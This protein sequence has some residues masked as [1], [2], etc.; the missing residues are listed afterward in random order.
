MPTLSGAFVQVLIGNAAGTLVDIS[1]YLTSVEPQRASVPIDL[2]TFAAGGVPV[3][4]NLVRGAAQSEFT[5]KGLYDPAFA[6]IIRQIM[7]ARG[8]FTLQIRSGSN[9]IPAQGDSLFE[10]AQPHPVQCF[11]QLRLPA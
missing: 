10:L 3:T 7:A 1:A 9:A 8:G 2:S 6:K 4:S 11:I 5:L